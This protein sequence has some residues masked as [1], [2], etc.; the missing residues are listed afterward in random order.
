MS[1]LFFW[2]IKFPIMIM[3]FVEHRRS[4]KFSGQ[5]IYKYNLIW[6]S[7]LWSR[8]LLKIVSV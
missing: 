5:F 1:L 7:I 8:K 6:I 4:W 3:F 2:G